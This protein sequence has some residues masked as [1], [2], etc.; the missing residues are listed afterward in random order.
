M[1]NFLQ[2][3]L[4]QRFLGIDI[5]TSY[6]KIAEI[7]RF[8]HRRKLENYGSLSSLV[9]YEKPFRT[10]EKNSLF[11]SS[12]DIA[13]AIKAIMEESKIKSR[14]A[15]FSIPDFSTFFTN[16]ELPQMTTEEL[17]QAVRYEAKQ[18]IPFPLSEMTLDWRVI[19]ENVSQKEKNLKILLA[20]VPNEVINQYRT[21]SQLANLELYGLEA[22]VFSLI[23]SLVNSEEREPVGLIDVGAQSTT[24]SIVYRKNLHTSHSFNMSGNDFTATLSK[25]LNIDYEKAEALKKEE[26]LK[27]EILIPLIDVILKEAEII[28]NSFSQEEKKEVK[29][30]ILGGG[31]ALLPGLKDYFAEK[32]AKEILIANPFANLFYPPILEQELKEMGPAY[33]IAVGAALRGLD[34]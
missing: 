27:Q 6:I 1:F 26:G 32:L 7:S 2:V 10:F 31:S 25:G 20:A 9:L 15:V 19:G 24:C 33:S 29:K 23:R 21:I 8:G 34:Y 22:E 18:H 13:K 17:S 12:S 28:F 16:F 11:L 5:G 4:P 14:Q 30:V 3:L